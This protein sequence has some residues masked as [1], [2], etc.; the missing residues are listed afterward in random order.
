[1]SSVKE[2]IQLQSSDEEIVQSGDEE[3]ADVA[4]EK[5]VTSPRNIHGF[6]VSTSPASPDMSAP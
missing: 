4:G 6:R 3:R 5:I 1:M 2:P